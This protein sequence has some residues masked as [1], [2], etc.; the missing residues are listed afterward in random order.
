MTK[1]KAKDSYEEIKGMLNTIR[2]LN[3]NYGMIKEQ[4]EAGQQQQPVQQSA[5]SPVQH[6]S[7]TDQPPVSS[8]ENIFVINDVDVE[9]HSEDT[10]DLTLNDTEK[11]Q[12]SQLIDDFRAQVSEIAEF[13]RLDIYP[14]SAKL[15]GTIPDKG[16]GFTLSTGDDT[17][18][19]L[20]NTSMLKIDND[21]VTVINLL[22][23]FEA[24]FSDTI[25]DLLVNRRG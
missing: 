5:Q 13:D 7:V 12:I 3:S 20:S 22:K 9:I 8:D 10:M 11:G 6:Q 14:D 23:S 25:N 1:T 2:R 17:G 19:F 16:I 18:L 21:Y 15:S 4:A 24:K